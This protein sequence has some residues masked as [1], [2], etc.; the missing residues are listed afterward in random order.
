MTGALLV[1][2]YLLALACFLGYDVVSKVAPTLYTALL[3]GMNAMNGIVVV[4][5]LYLARGGI[6]SAGGI[7]GCVT[8]GLG[9]MAA[10]G[11]FVATHRLLGPAGGGRGAGD[12]GRSD[13]GRQ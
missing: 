8:V 3:T 7:L 2:V 11:G 9:T 4:A 12:A 1:S 5:G 6:D 13:G 10:V